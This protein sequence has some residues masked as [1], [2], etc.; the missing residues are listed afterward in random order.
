MHQRHLTAEITELIARTSLV[1]PTGVSKCGRHTY[2]FR[3]LSGH[4]S[5]LCFISFFLSCPLLGS[6]VV[7]L[8]TGTNKWKWQFCRSE[9]QRGK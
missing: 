8:G 2:T 4:I 3:A 5:S 6:P 7:D 1:R 9:L